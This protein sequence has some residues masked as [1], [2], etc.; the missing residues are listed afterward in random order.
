M[1]DCVMDLVVVKDIAIVGFGKA[2]GKKIAI[3]NQNIFVAAQPVAFVDAFNNFY[4]GN[5]ENSTLRFE[6]FRVLRVS[7]ICAQYIIYAQHNEFTSKFLGATP[8]R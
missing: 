6:W 8:F 7:M 4:F 1:I 3:T 5:R 2:F